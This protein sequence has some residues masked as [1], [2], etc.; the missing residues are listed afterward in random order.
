[1]WLTRRFVVPYYHSPAVALFRVS[2]APLSPAYGPDLVSAD[3]TT[4][5]ESFAHAGIRVDVT[6]GRMYL[7][8]C[9]GSAHPDFANAVLQLTWLDERGTHIR[10]D[11]ASGVFLTKATV[12]RLISTSPARASAASITL[13]PLGGRAPAITRVSFCEVRFGPL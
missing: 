2:S 4:G 12:L 3:D 13:D 8:T 9:T 1:E 10:T 5:K 6:E 11:E 7:F